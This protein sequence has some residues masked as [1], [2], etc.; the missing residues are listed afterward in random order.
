MNLLKLG[1]I[2]TP[3]IGILL[4]ILTLS[5]PAFAQKEQSQCSVHLEAV[6]TPPRAEP[7]SAQPAP[8]RYQIFE[9]LEKNVQML[10]FKIENDLEVTNSKLESQELVHRDKINK[11]MQ[12][13]EKVWFQTSELAEK[14]PKLQELVLIQDEPLVKQFKEVDEKTKSLKSDYDYIVNLIENYFNQY[15]P[16]NTQRATT[17][18]ELLEAPEKVIA[19]HKYHLATPNGDYVI[20]FSQEIV[21]TVFLDTKNIQPRVLLRSL[22]DAQK[23]VF[24]AKYEGT[25][26]KRLNSDKNIVEIRSIGDNANFRLFGYIK[27]SE[28]YIVQYTISSNHSSANLYKHLLNKV[29]EAKRSRGH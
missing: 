25:G 12:S 10:L 13:L 16:N 29:Y 20:I 7:V 26:I 18:D 6:E 8:A 5:S 2:S 3:F 22:K 14:M 19:D 28:I 23:G 27:D 17:Y 15:S 24:G 1:P 4:M 21:E 11:L 9:I